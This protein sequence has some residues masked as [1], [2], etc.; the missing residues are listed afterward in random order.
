M[1]ITLPETADWPVGDEMSASD[2]NALVSGQASFGV[3]PPASVDAV[4]DW[5]TSEKKFQAKV[6]KYA[7]EHGW[8]VPYH[9][10]NSA[11]SQPGFPDLVFKRDGRVRRVAELK[12]AGKK[13]TKDQREWLDAF[14]AAGIPADVWCPEMWEEIERILR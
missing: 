4:E 14:A 1:R 7:I 11:S 5:R 2:F 8:D 9:T 12:V 6:V 3:I 10:F 13:P